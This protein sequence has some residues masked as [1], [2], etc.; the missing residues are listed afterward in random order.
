MGVNSI[1]SST[2][3]GRFIGLSDT[4]SSYAGQSGLIPAVNV[5]ETGLEFISPSAGSIN[6][7]YDDIQTALTIPIYQQMIVHQA[8]NIA[9]DLT[10][11]GKLVLI[12]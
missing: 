10:I 1:V 9:S 7:S 11:L 12:G 2:S 4:P 3:P 6:F 5:D 8:I